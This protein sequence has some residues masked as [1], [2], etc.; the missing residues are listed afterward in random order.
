MK[1]LGKLSITPEKVVKN[2]EL[3][4][5][6]GGYGTNCCVC[7]DDAGQGDELGYIVGVSRI[8]CLAEDCSIPFPNHP[9]ATP[10]WVC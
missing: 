4:N 6:R 3:V 5:L 7:K 10:E 2:E 8:E 1:T 9:E